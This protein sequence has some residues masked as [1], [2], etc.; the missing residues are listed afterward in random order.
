MAGH[1]TT[2]LLTR[3]AILQFTS[4]LAFDLQA[5][6]SL[7]LLAAVEQA[8]GTLEIVLSVVGV[9]ITL[10]WAML[11][12][13]MVRHCRYALAWLFFP[14]AAT[15][16]AYVSYKMYVFHSDWDYYDDLVGIPGIIL[17]VTALLF[18]GLVVVTAIIVL[19][20]GVPATQPRLVG[21]P[22]VTSPLLSSQP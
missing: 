19:R 4:F 22:S 16:P 13:V 2:K 12:R 9:F 20:R 14:W 7:L 18:R 10:G 5:W 17:A 6:V 15:L 3:S 11:G 8:V 1:D 21:G